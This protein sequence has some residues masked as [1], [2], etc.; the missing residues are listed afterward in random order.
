MNCLMRISEDNDD[1]VPV[2]DRTTMMEILTS[3]WQ[4]SQVHLATCRGFRDNMFTVKLDGTEDHLGSEE[5]K[6]YWSECN[7]KEMRRQV[8][9]DVE[10]AHKAGD[11][12][13]TFESYM[14][15]MKPFPRQGFMDVSEPGYEDEGS[16][17]QEGEV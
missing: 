2:L 10:D 8:L 11:L 5:C 4:R 6:G 3:I 13:L 15:L 7:M 12:P 16:F 9:A 1:R 17:V 14:S